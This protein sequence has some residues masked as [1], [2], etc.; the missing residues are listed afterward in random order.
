M[1][2]FMIHE[3]NVQNSSYFVD[4]VIKIIKLHEYHFPTNFT[5]LLY[6]LAVQI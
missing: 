6:A 4:K 2:I 5:Q 3:Q 1:R